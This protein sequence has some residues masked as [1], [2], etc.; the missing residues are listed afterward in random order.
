MSTA[1]FDRKIIIKDNKTAK[2]L[3]D[4]INNPVES[5]LMKRAKKINSELALKRGRQLLKKFK[6]LPTY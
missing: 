1:T 6:R 4:V 5:D 2:I 3:C